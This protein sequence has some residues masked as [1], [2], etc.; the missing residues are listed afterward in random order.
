MGTE[1]ASGVLR[2]SSE[3]RLL[4]WLLR[5][6]SFAPLQLSVGS[7]LLL[8]RFQAALLV[9]FVTASWRAFGR[10]LLVRISAEF[11]FHYSTCLLNFFR[12]RITC[13]RRTNAIARI[14]RTVAVSKSSPLT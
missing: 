12:T 10:L 7:Y 14:A 1:G 9:L 2:Q 13:H 5:F 8:Y 6:V 4:F 11:T 3:L